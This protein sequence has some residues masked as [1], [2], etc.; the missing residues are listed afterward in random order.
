MDIKNIQN[1]SQVSSVRLKQI[2]IKNKVNKI[3]KAY[4]IYRE[5]QKKNATVSYMTNFNTNTI[6]INND[7]DTNG[8]QQPR[9]LDFKVSIQVSCAFFLVTS[10][11]NNINII[12]DR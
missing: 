6:N 7:N 4:R 2:A 8:T 5:R 1:S 12:G 9:R 11:K 10:N 3:I